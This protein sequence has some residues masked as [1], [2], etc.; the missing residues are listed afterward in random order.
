MFEEARS[1]F[2]KKSAQK[3]FAPLRAGLEPLAVP[4][5]A[6]RTKSFFGYF[7]FKKSNCFL[8]K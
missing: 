4:P 5:R 6:K 7:F 3:T 2:L 8:P 1:A